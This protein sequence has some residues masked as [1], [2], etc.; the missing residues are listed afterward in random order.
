ML[1]THATTK[2]DIFLNNLS[3][4]LELSFN[5]ALPYI[6]FKSFLI[7]CSTV[8]VGSAVKSFFNAFC[9]ICFVKPSITSADIASSNTS[10]VTWLLSN[11]VSVDSFILSLRS[12]I[13]RSAVFA[14]IPF[15]DFKMPTFSEAMV[16]S[17]SEGVSYDS[18]MRA[19]LAPTPDTEISNR[20]NSRSRR[21]VKP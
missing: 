18:I 19:V 2:N 9:D 5:F 12:T 7:A 4:Y 13:I 10:L 8:I 14:P 21:S 6:I 20:N 17:R 16:C 11:N 3:N 15:T 1:S